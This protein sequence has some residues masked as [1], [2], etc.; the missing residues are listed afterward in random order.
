MRK[1]LPLLLAALPAFAQIS[2]VVI[3]R[4]T[5]Q[6]QAN[7]SVGI[8]RMTSQGPQPG[9][10]TKSGPDGK[11]SFPD[12]LQGPTL[13]RA[14]VD[15]VPYNQMLPPGSP[16]TNITL[17]VYNASKTPGDAKVSKHMILFEP[18]DGKIQVNETFL[19]E[20]AGK[21]AWNDASTGTLRFFAP[22][23]STAIQINATPPGGM[24]IPAS[25]EKAGQPDIYKVDFPVRPGETR[26]DLTYS[27]PYK[28]G[29]QLEGKIATKDDNTYLIVPN[30]VTLTAENVNDLG[31]EPRSQA[32]IY[33]LTKNT[34][35]IQLTGA[36]VAPPADQAQQQ[37]QDSGPQITPI[38]PRIYTQVWPIM[39]AAFGILALGFVLLYRKG[40]SAFREEEA[41]GRR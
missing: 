9:P 27:F 23:G 26:F 20:N 16:S 5:G 21:T 32:H 8:L 12:A 4:T 29:G 17:D 15:G 6:P 13:L 7:A 33:G 35:N 25:S 39:G 18:A 41:H 2:G 10:E 34:Y 31:V 14:T 22:S 38:L 36:E 19:Y 3:N 1:S 40:S 28:I 37:D 11:F 24:P 30:G